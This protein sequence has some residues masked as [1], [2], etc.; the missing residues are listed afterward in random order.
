MNE[1]YIELEH[2]EESK[3][4]S[5]TKI[6]YPYIKRFFDILFGLI[7]CLF[8]IPLAIIIKIAYMLSGDMAPIFYRQERI[9]KGGKTIYIFKFR[10]MVPNADKKL[11]EILKHNKE[12]R[13][14]YTVYKKLKDDPRITKIGRF[15]RHGSIDEMPQF[16]NIFNGDM[17]LIGNRPYLPREKKDMS[18]L[19]DEIVK[20]K[21]G[22]TG[23]WQVNGRSNVTFK[24]RCKMEAF[25]SEFQGFRFDMMIFVKTIKVVLSGF[26]AK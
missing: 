6:I 10:T 7:G 1:S 22:L 26:G 8:I 21:P 18:D 15:I 13:E 20:S 17:S 23:Y 16:I 3:T 25:Y 12:L 4:L 14:E 19:Y 24:D 2:A 9:G 5:I 11:K